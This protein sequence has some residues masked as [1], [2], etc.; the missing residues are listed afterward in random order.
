MDGYEGEGQGSGPRD[1]L[2]ELLRRA[3]AEGAREQVTS[4]TRRRANF[5]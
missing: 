4:R 2:A 3:A 5:N 1:V